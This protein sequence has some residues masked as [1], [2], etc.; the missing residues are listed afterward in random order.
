[1]FFRPEPAVE[2]ASA[3]GAGVL[4]CN[5][6]TPDAPTPAATRR[7]LAEF[8]S[9]RRV[10]ELPPLLWQPILH[11]IILRT[12]PARSAAKYQ[13]IWRP[14]GSPLLAHSQK[15]AAL[16]RGYL[17]ERGCPVNVRL[18]MR[19]GQPS[20]AS[21][22][23]ELKA[24]GCARVL[25][26]PLYP[27]YSAATTASVSDAVGAWARR[28]RHVPELRFMGDFHDDPLYIGALAWQVRRHWQTQGRA[29]RLVMSFHGLPERASALGDPYVRQCR[30]T[31]SLLAGE[32]GL[33]DGEWAISFQSRFGRARWVG[34][35][36]QT[37]LRELGRAGPP[38]VE[39][40]C[41]GF[42]SDCLE[43]LEEI[44]IEG[45]AAFMAAGGRQ[46][47]Y[48]P[49]LNDQP[50]WLAALTAIV[51]RHLEPVHSLRWPAQNPFRDGMQ[52]AARRP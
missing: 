7:Y 40:I 6:G 22:L 10:V 3:G 45:R 36:T 44:A 17:G 1:M 26:A 32:L 41:P 35:A 2:P 14:E 38:S 46:F 21:Q 15:Q 12:R 50:A 48:I 34:P 19:Y 11:G 24:S 52:G 16:L 37:V 30:K 29:D 31:A 49:C 47:S 25:V 4:L 8:L 20:I 28:T 18:A 27:Q 51:Q 5:L 43:T 39:V 33:K 23:D 13:A 42:V 9:D